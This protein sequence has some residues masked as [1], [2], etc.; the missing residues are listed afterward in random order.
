MCFLTF[1]LLVVI[2]FPPFV[3]CKSVDIVIVSHFNGS[4]LCSCC[5]STCTYICDFLQ[6]TVHIFKN[7]TDF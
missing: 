3:C 6:A 7:I 1:V 2:C 4:Y 5:E